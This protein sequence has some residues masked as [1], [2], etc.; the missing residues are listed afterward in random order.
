MEKHDE[1]QILAATKSEMG[2]WNGEYDRNM[3]R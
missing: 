2:G 1:K 3:N